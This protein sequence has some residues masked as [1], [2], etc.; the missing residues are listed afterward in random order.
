MR[1]RCRCEEICHPAALAYARD[2]RRKRGIPRGTQYTAWTVAELAALIEPTSAKE[3]A[4]KLGR[5]EGAVMKQRSR[6]RAVGAVGTNSRRSLA[7]IHPH[8]PTLLGA[9]A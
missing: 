9:G 3:C 7:G 2:L 4:E 6:I 5:T 1:N 8:T